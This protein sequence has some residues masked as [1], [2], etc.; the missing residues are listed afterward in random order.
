MKSVQYLFASSQYM[1][2]RELKSLW[3]IKTAGAS[4]AVRLEVV[5]EI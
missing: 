3:P 4:S 5:L 2:M 1:Y